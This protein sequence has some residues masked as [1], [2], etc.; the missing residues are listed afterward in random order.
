[1]ALAWG[2]PDFFLWISLI[3]FVIVITWDEAFRVEGAIILTETI[4]F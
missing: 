1:M 4:Q 3:L 2:V